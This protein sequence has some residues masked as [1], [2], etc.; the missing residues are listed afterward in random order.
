[1]HRWTIEKLEDRQLLSSYVHPSVPAESRTVV[2]FNGDWSFIRQDVGGA[3]SPS[4]DDSSWTGITLPHTY[5]AFDGQDGGNDYYRGLAWYRKAFDVPSRWSTRRIVMKMDGV[6]TLGK[7][8]VNGQF[9]AEHRGASAS[10]TADIGPFLTPGAR[11]TIAV[12]VDNRQSNDIAPHRGDFTIFGGIYRDVSLLILNRAHVNPLD[13]GSPGVWI[14]QSNVSAQRADINIRTLVRN[15]WADGREYAIQADLYDANGHK[16]NG[17]NSGVRWLRARQWRSIYINTSI[18][19]PRLWDGLNDPYLYT[20]R[21]GVRDNQGNELDSI[22]QPLGL[23][24][25]RIDPVQGFMLNGRRY[26]L[27]GAGL[28]EDRLNKG[29]AISDADREQDLNLILDMGG[30]AV[31]L[32]HWQHDPYTYEYANRKGIIVWTEIPIWGAIPASGRYKDNVKIQLQELIRQN[33]NHPSVAIWGLFNEVADDEATRT[34]AGELHA[35]AKAEDPIRMT[36]GA[37]W[38]NFPAALNDIPD[39]IGFNKYQGWYGNRI[40]AFGTWLAGQVTAAGTRSFAMTE[41]G[42]GGSIVQ[43]QDNPSRPQHDGP[44]H[45]EQY[46]SLFHEGYWNEIK[47]YPQIWGVFVWQLTDSANDNRNEGDTA[48]RNDKGLVTYDRENKKDA[49]YF[50]RAAWNDRPVLHL[51]AKRFTNRTDALPPLRVYTNIGDVT[52]L[53]N[54]QTIGT[55]ADDD[56]D[57]IVSWTNVLLRQGVNTIE[58][59]ATRN[60]QTYT[61]TAVWNLT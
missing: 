5:N 39:T 24:D 37:S 35:I 48:G 60:G 20:L 4:F 27:R 19:N 28:H 7:L 40:S 50:Y 32:V 55:R 33:Y 14:T 34:L 45:P 22:Y 43:H 30:N 52:L 8:F 2:N 58:V 61:D 26:Q 42:A 25:M 41:Y 3:E 56:N 44:F 10:W 6:N 17:W 18:N 47:K 16:V 29:R 12:Q 23:R 57:N 38:H 21:I 9:V 1:M 46:Q 59:R 31:R 11:N 36:S 53:I 54:G 15:S 13:R 49:F 51:T